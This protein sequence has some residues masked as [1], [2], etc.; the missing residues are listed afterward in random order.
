MGNVCRVGFPRSDL[1]V[2]VDGVSLKP[3][4]ALGGWLAFEAMGITP[5]SW[6]TPC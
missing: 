4:F 5:W 3:R 2:T 1:K 6:A